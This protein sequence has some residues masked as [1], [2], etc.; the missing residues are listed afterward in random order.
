MSLARVRTVGRQNVSAKCRRENFYRERAKSVYLVGRLSVTG[1]TSN[2][3]TKLGKSVSCDTL[4][5]VIVHTQLSKLNSCQ[6]PSWSYPVGVT[7]LELPSCQLPSC[8]L[9]SC[10][11]PSCQLPSCQLPSCQLPS[12]Q[13]PSCQLPSCQL[14]SCQ[15][16]SCQLPSC[17]LP[18]CQL[19]SCQLPSCQLPSCQLPSCQLPSCQLPSCQLPSCQLPSCQLPSCLGTVLGRH[20]EKAWKEHNGWRLA[21]YFAYSMYSKNI[22]VSRTTI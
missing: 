19:P 11:L 10:Q 21:Q 12:C 22:K 3:A 18:S 8:Q 1:D 15:L 5:D 16:P 13:L 2:T 4:K 17:Q 20:F 6:L 9:P 14:P 7:Q